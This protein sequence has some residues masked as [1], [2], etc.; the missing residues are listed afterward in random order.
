L[1]G[2]DDPPTTPSLPDDERRTRSFDKVHS[3]RLLDRSEIAFLDLDADSSEFA[4][5]DLTML[6]PPTSLPGADLPEEDPELPP[7]TRLGPFE[8]TGKLGAGAMSVVY[9]GVHAESGREVAIK[10]MGLRAQGAADRQMLTERFRRETVAVSRVKHPNVI[11]VYSFGMAQNR[12]F[13]VL[14]LL[15]GDVGDLLQDHPR[16]LP[17][18]HALDIAKGTLAGLGAA[19]AQGFLHRDIKPDNLMLDETGRVKVADFGLVRLQDA[20]ANPL[21]VVGTAV[22]TP[23]YMAPEQADGSQVDHR[24]DLYAVGATLYHMLCGQPPFEARNIITLT[25]LKQGGAPTD[26]RERRSEVPEALDM[27]VRQLLAPRP[28]DRFQTAADARVALEAS[29]SRAS[30]RL[31]VQLTTE[32]ETEEKLLR[33]GQTVLIGRSGQRVDYVVKDPSLSRQHCL[34]VTTPDDLLV[35]DLKSSNGTRVTG[36]L[37]DHSQ[38]LRSGDVLEIGDS[39]IVIRFGPE[40]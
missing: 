29:V 26:L 6:E 34:L 20:S 12:P 38:T 1:R 14:E 39:K 3:S 7:G 19:H 8:V 13:M 15:A 30:S 2:V 10:V 18:R 21:T 32:G 11:K 36:R 31:R 4:A 37:V 22:G 23:W 17:I 28:Q 5:G 9:R 35:V 16:G 40:G 24:A 25:S 27:A 33:Q